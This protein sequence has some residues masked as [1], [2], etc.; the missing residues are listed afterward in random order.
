MTPRTPAPPGSPEDAQRRYRRRQRFLRIGQAVM[1]LGFLVA[2]IHWL[3]HLEAFG[4]A[5]PEGWID[6]VAGYPMGALLLVAGAILAS[7][8]TT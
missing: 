8:K 2:L 4:P 1:A 3:A 6:L 7:R 5:Q